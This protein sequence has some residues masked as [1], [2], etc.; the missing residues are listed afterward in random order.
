M[1]P[2]WAWSV[3]RKSHTIAIGHASFSAILLGVELFAAKPVGMTMR[4]IS[5][6]VLNPLDRDY[7]DSRPRCIPGATITAWNGKLEIDLDELFQKPGSG[8]TVAGSTATTSVSQPR[9]APPDEAKITFP[10]VDHLP[11][12][13]IL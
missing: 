4:K 5:K 10:T 3:G 9:A 1:F 6:A 7:M 11:T 2:V 8:P 12:V 13:A